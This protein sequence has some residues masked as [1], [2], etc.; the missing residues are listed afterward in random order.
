MLSDIFSNIGIL[1]TRKLAR[2]LKITTPPTLL[3]VLDTGTIMAIN[4]PYSA[5]LKALTIE[6]GRIL[7]ATIPRAVPKDQ[8]GRAMAIAP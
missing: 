7:P 1:D 8:L 4:M 2:K 3:L 6:T 5:T